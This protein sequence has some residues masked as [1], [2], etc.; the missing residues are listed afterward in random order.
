[1]DDVFMNAVFGDNLE[2]TSDLLKVILENDR[3]DVKSSK[4]QYSIKNV[5]GHSAVLDIFAQDEFGRNFNVEIQRLDSGAVPQRARYYVGLIDSK[6]FPSG[7]KY[8]DIK[9][10]YVVFITEHDILGYGLPIYHINRKINE[11]GADFDDGAYIIYVNGEKRTEQ[12]PLGNLMHD[13]F[14]QDAKD[15]YDKKL[16]ARV[17]YLKDDQGGVNEMCELMQKLF[18]KEVEEIKHNERMQ[19]AENMLKD[20]VSIENAAKWSNLSR[21]DV[22]AIARRIA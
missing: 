3:I 1:M 2:L 22:E 5:E 21:E 12:T 20:G 4:A 11:N 19:H 6:F 13:F 18:D 16:A 7:E 14:C 17:S 15:M 8:G 10:T 9:D